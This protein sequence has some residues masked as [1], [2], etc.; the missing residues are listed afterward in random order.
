MSSYEIQIQPM[1]ERKETGLQ[2]VCH[3]DMQKGALKK[4][5]THKFIQIFFLGSHQTIIFTK[6]ISNINEALCIHKHSHQQM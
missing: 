5:K 4:K 2:P 6:A 1:A 3:D